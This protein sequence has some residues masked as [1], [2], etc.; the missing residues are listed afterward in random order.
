MPKD[1]PIWQ[2]IDGTFAK[3]QNI[4]A[5]CHMIKHRG[6]LTDALVKSH[7]C[8]SKKCRFFELTNHRY[9]VTANGL[10]KKKIETE[11]PTD[12]TEQEKNRLA[13]RQEIADAR[14]RE[15]IIREILEASGH[16]YVTAIRD[17]GQNV[18]EICFIYDKPTHFG[19]DTI[20]LLREKFWKRIKLRACKGSEEAIEKLI[21]RPRRESGNVTDVRK[22]PGIGDATKKRMAALGVYCLEDMHGHSGVELYKRDCELSG[23]KVNRRYLTAYRNA[24]KYAS[25]NSCIFR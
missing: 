13:K 17:I 19:A 3:K 11:D 24:E 22:V 2:C 5:Y 14:A 23:K 8:I 10:K 20:E 18:L 25:N 15:A 9:Y 7:G 1:K 12:E 16:I 6:H 4:R 21:R